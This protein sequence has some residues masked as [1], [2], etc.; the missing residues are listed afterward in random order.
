VVILKAHTDIVQSIRDDIILDKSAP[1]LLPAPR[2]SSKKIRA[3]K[4]HDATTRRGMAAAK[5]AE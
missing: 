4:A 1:F 2:I 3:S 5:A